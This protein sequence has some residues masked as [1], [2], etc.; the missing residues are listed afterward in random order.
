VNVSSD[1]GV[2][3]LYLVILSEFETPESDA[4]VST[5]AAVPVGSEIVKFAL[6]TSKK[7]FPTADTFT[8]ADAV[9]APSAGTWNVAVP[10]FVVDAASTY[11]Y[12]APPS[13]ERVIC[14]YWSLIA[15]PVVIPGVH[16]TDCV[17]PSAHV[18][19]VVFGAVTANGV[20]PDAT[21]EYDTD[22]CA[23]PPAPSRAVTSHLNADL[24]TVGSRSDALLPVVYV[25]VP[26]ARIVDI[27][28]R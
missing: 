28:G 12:V 1:A 18:A 3:L 8:R 27:I 23:T 16:V 11:G 4:A 17:V 24:A 7:M 9:A 6:L 20:D 26:P 2:A 22:D 5:G 19:F 10:V 15:A 13:V 25:F 21:T 14:T